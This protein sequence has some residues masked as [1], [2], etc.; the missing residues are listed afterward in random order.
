MGLD[1]YKQPRDKKSGKWYSDNPRWW[2]MDLR[3]NT[4]EREELEDLAEELDIAMT[5]VVVNGIRLL[6][7]KLEAE[8]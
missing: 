6:R 4:E 8:G 2:R 1:W 7:Q 3:L 5:D